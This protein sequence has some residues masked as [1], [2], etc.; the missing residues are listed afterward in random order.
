MAIVWSS[1]ANLTEPRADAV[2][3]L[4]ADQSVYVLGGNSIGVNKLSP[5]SS[6]WEESDNIDKQRV[7]PGVGAI[8]DGRVLLFG[9]ASGGQAIE[10]T[11]LFDPVD[12][13]PQDGASMSSMR[14]QSAYATN[15]AT[16]LIYAFGGVNDES[17]LLRSAEVYSPASDSWSAIADMPL[18]RADF[19]AASDGAGNIF[20][21]GGRRAGYGTNDVSSDVYRYN[22]AAN[23]WTLMAPMPAALSDA[24]AVSGPGNGK[25]Y[26]VGGRGTSGPVATTYAYDFASNTWESEAS[27]PYAVTGASAVMTADGRL[28]LIGGRN[29][30]GQLLSSVEVSQ[31][32]DAEDTLP[33]FVSS[34]PTT[35]TATVN[36]SYQAIA[37]GNPQATFDLVMAPVGMSITAGGQLSWLPNDGQ[38]TTH[39]VVVRAR[40]RS[41]EVTQSFVLQVASAIPVITSSPALVAATGAA[42]TYD[43]NSTG[44]PAAS[45]SLSAAPAGMTINAVSGVVSW[46]PTSAQAGAVTVSVVAQNARG[47]DEQTF[48]IDVADKIAPTAPTSLA[49]TGLTLTSVSMSWNT[50]TDNIAVAKYVIREQYKY[51]WR[52][53]LTG[54]RIIKDNITTNS[55]TLTGLV[56]GKA[57]NLTVSAVD[58]SGNES[59][60]SNMIN[61]RAL[62]L[63]TIGLSNISQSVV[64]AHAMLNIGVYAAGV[65][66]PT[67]AMISGPSGMVFDPITRVASWLPTDSQVGVHTATF[68]ATNSQ[69]IAN[70]SATITVT[71][72]LPVPGNTFS[73]F[74]TP[75][76]VPFAVEGDSFD[77]LLK[78]SYSNSP[79]TWSVASGPAGLTVNPST[80]VVNWIPTSADV[81]T[82]NLVLRATNYAGSSNLSL[83]VIVHPIGTDLRP[84]T[85]V[86]GIAV[87]IID[88][89]RAAV[90]WAPSTDNAGIQSYQITA[91][92]RYQAGRYQKTVTHIFDAPADATMLEMTGLAS[93]SQTVSIRAKDTSG[94]VSSAGQVVTFTPVSNPL[95]PQIQLS[96]GLQLQNVV[97]GVNRSIQLTD[98][99]PS[100]RTYA[101]LNGPT[102]AS[103]NAASG[104][105]NW[106]PNYSQVGSASFTIRATNGS[107]YRDLTF[108][109]P[110]YFTGP[111]QNL[112]YT[113]TSPNLASASWTSPADVANVIGYVVQQEWKSNGHTYTRTFRV[114]GAT[115]NRK[116]G[117]FFPT[118]AAFHRVRVYATDALGRY[119]LASATVS[120][121]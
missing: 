94:N 98:T 88:S 102:G 18:A 112:A 67:V 5:N 4:G 108:A 19:A 26:I 84:P 3:V 61:T 17:V 56:S 96:D 99:N 119:G 93:R 29:A 113:I 30:L 53:S 69:G 47:S 31:D 73:Y 106:T 86:S 55:T 35:A 115:T 2:A 52:N 78:E 23:S 72:N 7:S 89:T 66:A 80:G 77:L 63:P 62:Q 16:G 6:A 114:D 38:A 37:T 25:I 43:A 91:S 82:V 10:E 41:G 97:V 83:N 116:D 34:P 74:G 70:I 76:T 15:P 42:Y 104:L 32:L 8:T 22:I 64:A 36:Y 1:G 110:V 54:Y 90:T 40:N 21:F 71:A 58:A 68:R 14:A 105:I 107:G 27:L 85:P 48:T 79:I 49:V 39:N 51:G 60:R 118:G 87:S 46:T 92:Y 103:I 11:Y 109:F 100:P 95:F 44:A 111:V 59:L 121:Q 33:V 117:L 45:Y 101:I 57:Y 20:T 120:L 12:G 13:N 65:P 50:S 81:G 24:A 9:G 75:H 28:L